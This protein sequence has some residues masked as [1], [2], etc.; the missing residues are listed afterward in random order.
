M[1]VRIVVTHPGPLPSQG[2][3][4]VC[5]CVQVNTSLYLH[6][7]LGIMVI[8]I[9]LFTCGISICIAVHIAVC[10]ELIPKPV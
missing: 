7:M 10:I 4:R 9:S 3:H 5:L 1:Q 8:Y 6:V 2:V